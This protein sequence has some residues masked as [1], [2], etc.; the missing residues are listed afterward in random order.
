MHGSFHRFY[1]SAIHTSKQQY[2]DERQKQAIYQLV[3]NAASGN[4]EEGAE[5]F[6]FDE[7]LINKAQLAFLSGINGQVSDTD[8]SSVDGAT[9]SSTEKRMKRPPMENK[10]PV[11]S[12]ATTLPPHTSLAQV[13]ANQYNINIADV[14][15]LDTEPNAKITA[16]DVEYHLYKV[17]Q[18]PCTPQAL[19]LAYSLG[20]DLNEMYEEYAED[21]EDDK[22]IMRISD[23]ELYQQNL[24]SLRASSQRRKRSGDNAPMPLKKGTKKL[25]ELEDRIDKRIERLSQ[26]AKKVAGSVAGAV[27]KVQS[28]V[29]LSTAKRPKKKL[30]KVEYS[31]VQDFDTDLADEIQAALMSAGLSGDELDEISALSSETEGA[32]EESIEENRD[33]QDD[34]PPNLFFLDPK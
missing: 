25:N 12:K 26:N 31:S 9:S 5:D 28:Q 33:N 17:S 20:L 19:E 34:L 15:P 7:E 30:E 21:E 22:Y 2:Q 29:K 23:V 27:Q 13:I 1:S 11:Q 4:K 32:V 3:M 10:A 18:P 14:T 24:R 6:E 16:A 8:R